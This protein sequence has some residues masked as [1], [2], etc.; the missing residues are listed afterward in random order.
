MVFRQM[1]CIGGGIETSMQIDYTA[2]ML[3]VFE[4]KILTKKALKFIASTAYQYQAALQL[5][6]ILNFSIMIC[7]VST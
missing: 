6:I 7:F 4:S 3:F 5:S 2:G 1:R